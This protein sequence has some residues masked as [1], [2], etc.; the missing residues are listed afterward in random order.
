MDWLREGSRRQESEGAS[1]AAEG[2]RDIAGSLIPGVKSPGAGA[3]Q[4][5]CHT[6]SAVCY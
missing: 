5:A 4:V 1:G 3:N 6:H 2:G